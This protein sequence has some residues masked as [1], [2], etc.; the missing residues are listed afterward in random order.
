MKITLPAK[1]IA[2]VGQKDNTHKFAVIVNETVFNM[3]T[4]TEEGYN[5]ALNAT[6]GTANGMVPHAK[7]GYQFVKWTKE[8]T[9][10]A[11]AIED[12]E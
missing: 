9:A 7:T 10:D 1:V 5:G 2:E 11:D 4:N 6:T 12:P 8:P 3:V